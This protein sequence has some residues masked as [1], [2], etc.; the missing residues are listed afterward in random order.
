[1]RVLF[2]CGLSL[3]LLAMHVGCFESTG[4]AGYIIRNIVINAFIQAL[5]LAPNLLRDHK[6]L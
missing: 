5:L 4:Y 3:K 2:V 1:L 6:F